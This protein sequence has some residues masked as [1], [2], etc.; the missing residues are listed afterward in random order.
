MNKLKPILPWLP[1]ILLVLVVFYL[2]SALN[3][4]SSYEE[5]LGRA[6]EREK[7]LES[8]F[9]AF[10]DASKKD[11]NAKER[12]ILSKDADF[13]AEK[14]RLQKLLDEKPKVVEVIVWKTKEVYVGGDPRPPTQPGT[15]APPAVCV[16]MQGDS[17]QVIVSEVTYETK[18][19]NHVL[20]GSAACWRTKP[21]KS[22]LFTSAVEAPVSTAI[23]APEP[24]QKRWGAG[25]YMGFSKDGW[26][27]GPAVGFPPLPLW[28]LQA[29]VTAGVGLGPGGQFQ[30]GASGI[31]RW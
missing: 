29:E 2:V 8:S 26:A 17:G 4:A 1:V 21:T 12:E 14:E 13:K 5:Q 30:G 10:K 15:D 6:L 20:L 24:P 31:L 22:L 27:V 19:G 28:S 18:A 11:L 16:L 23:V 3:K 7:L 25:L 9:L